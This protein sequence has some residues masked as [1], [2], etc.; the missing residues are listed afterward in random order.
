MY[1]SKYNQR[2][3]IALLED[4]SGCQ[5]FFYGKMGEVTE[6]I[7]TFALPN[8][9][10][11]YTFKMNYSYDSWN[12]VQ[13]I[14]YPDGEVVSYNYDRGGMLN[15]MEGQKGAQSFTYI[16]NILYNRYG[17]KDEQW[18]GNGTHAK[19]DYDTLLRLSLMESWDVLGPM[20]HVTYSYDK[21]GNI[22]GIQNSAGMAATGLGGAYT[23]SYTYDSLYRLQGSTGGLNGM[24]NYGYWLDMAYEAN[25]RILRKSQLA[26]TFTS[27]S[28]DTL[29][30]YANLYS[31]G[32]S[33]SHNKVQSVTDNVAGSSQLF[34][35]DANG[36]LLTQG[37]TAQFRTHCWDELNR[38]QGFS[39]AKYDACFLYD[40]GGERF[41][42]FSGAP[43]A[44]MVNGQWST[45]HALT[46][47]T[48]YASPYLVATPKG[49]T[50]HYYVE[51]ERVASK[52]GGGGLQDLRSV[53]SATMSF[54]AKR[55]SCLNHVTR[56][57]GCLG[58]EISDMKTNLLVVLDQYD[59]SAQTSP[60]PENECYW[61]H[62]D[63][64]GS[65][66]W[67]SDKGGKGIQ[68]LYYLPWGEE[69][70]NQRAT[71][72]E[73]RYTFSGKERD[74]ETGYSYFGA[75]HYDSGL[76]LWLSVDPMADK[77]P[78]VSPYTYCGN[79]PV[80]LVDPDGRTIVDPNGEVCYTEQ[81]GW[82]PNA[83]EDTKRIGDAMMETNVGK[84][85]FMSMVNSKTKIQLI[86]NSSDNPDKFGDMKPFNPKKD[87]SGVITLK[88][89]VITIYE[90][91]ISDYLNET[92]P[93]NISEDETVMGIMACAA[94]P[95]IDQYM[96]AVACHEA[97]HLTPENLEINRQQATEKDDN[98]RAELRYQLEKE[99]E[100]KKY[101][102]FFQLSK[103][104][105]SN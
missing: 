22:T 15:K 31:Y 19:Y 69:L 58:V 84:E 97:E 17:L 51:S 86:I 105:K 55:D 42:K 70:A 25:G 4:A 24:K 62:S 33:P 3:R 71:G 28:S 68:Y 23:M 43:Q 34:T 56:V 2:G 12:R 30:N 88:A 98:K 39:D 63:H 40:A 64:L 47:P 1:Y 75:R 26:R 94:A 102:Y 104:K 44:M 79:N 57:T 90:R 54:A 74:E 9:S 103:Q 36:N 78:G 100:R 38:L 7:H 18:Y 89:A 96:G 13:S 8:E 5:T 29:M 93:G 83:P 21:V 81:D 77:S 53:C 67:V 82:L 50:K 87:Q 35:W 52:V 85:Q 61:Y 20:Q 72:Y 91:S 59:A 95:T 45:Y 46:D 99:P 6:N 101:L 32:A 66:S 16:D 65:A 27:T 92:L 37:T 11:P 41:Y 76:S 73:S 14:T 10:R 49:Y 60:N 48:L 80:R